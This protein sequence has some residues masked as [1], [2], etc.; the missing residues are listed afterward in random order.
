MGAVMRSKGARKANIRLR[1]V[2]QMQLG[3]SSCKQLV[4][5]CSCDTHL[6]CCRYCH[7]NS[8]PEGYEDLKPW[9]ELAKAFPKVTKGKEIY[10][11]AP[12][13]TPKEV[14]VLLNRCLKSQDSC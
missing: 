13:R 4:C 2:S 12:S 3:E 1:L 6:C 5:L 14:I 10:A 11:P 7:S 9:V 8:S